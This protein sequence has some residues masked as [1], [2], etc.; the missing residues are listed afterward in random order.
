VKQCAGHAYDL[1]EKEPMKNQS[2]KNQSGF[3]IIELVVV[4]I[5]LGI[6]AATALPRFMDVT[7]EAHDSVVAG[8]YGGMQTGMSL[9]H[10]QWIAE[11]QPAASVQIAEFGDLRTT[12]EGYPYGLVDNSGTADDVVNDADCGAVFTNVLQTGAPSISVVADEAAVVDV[13]TDFAT[14]EDS[15]DCLYYYTAAS[16]ANNA[17]VP[18]LSYDT[19]T[20]GI[21][22]A[23]VTLP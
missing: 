2:M 15:D 10:A 8:V 12:P 18:T 4:I 14:H 17:V 16:S 20:G 1:L 11:G 22:Q 23:T 3:T 5:L 7:D 9:Y 13:T 6:L 21:T 19:E